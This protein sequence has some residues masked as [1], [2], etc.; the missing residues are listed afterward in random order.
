MHTLILLRHGQS[1][2]NQENRFTGWADVDLSAQ[3]ADEARHA[4]RLMREA[5]L[6]VDVAFTSVLTR[7]IRTLW[8][9]LEEMERMWLP[10]AKSWRLNERHYGALQG[11]NKAETAARHGEAQVHAWRRG[12][13][14]RPDA[15]PE[16]DARDAFG[17]PRYSALQRSEVPRTESLADTVARVLPYWN[18]EIAAALRSG[19][20]T[21]IAAHGN[22]LRALVKHL[23]GISDEGIMEV[24]IPT[25]IPLVYRLADDFSILERGYLG[26]A[27]EVARAVVAVAAQGKVK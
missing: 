9:A 1:V 5:G 12:Y 19:Q 14:V 15:L 17:D 8:L 10:V 11:L 16:G 3:G 21:L 22:S 27:A 18:N 13:D 7:A 24:N 26:D 4:G 23:D 25:G 2:W 6:E 20:R